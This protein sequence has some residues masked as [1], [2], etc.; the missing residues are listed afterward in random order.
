MPMWCRGFHLVGGS[1]GSLGVALVF[2]HE[3]ES[4]PFMK[5]NL[6]LLFAA[7][8]LVHDGSGSTRQPCV[9]VGVEDSEGVMVG[10]GRGRRVG[11][12][13]G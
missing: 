6:L 10:G 13:V 3:K 12:K 7:V 8:K 4:A 5:L 11:G 1:S 2:Q 9:Q